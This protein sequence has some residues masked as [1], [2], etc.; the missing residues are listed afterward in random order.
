MPL[1]VDAF[2]KLLKVTS[3][4][5]S[6]TG[7]VLHNF[8]EDYMASPVGMMSDGNNASFLGDILKPEGKIEDPTNPGVFSIIILLLNPEWQIQYWGGSGYSK[9]TGAKIVGGVGDEPMKATGTAGDITVLE[10]PVDGSLIQSGTSGLTAGES[11]KLDN[12]DTATAFHTKIINNVKEL[13]KDGASL[14]LIIYDDGEVS[15]GIEILRKKQTDFNGNDITDLT[16][17]LLAAELESTT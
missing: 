16:A 4:D 6:V 14:Y 5:V 8:V 10:S 9:I 13:I 17:G 3:P 7:Q 15:G 11:A 2:N 12:I 1:E